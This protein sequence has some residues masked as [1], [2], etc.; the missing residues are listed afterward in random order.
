MKR[1]I[2]DSQTIIVVEPADPFL[3]KALLLTKSARPSA[4]AKRQ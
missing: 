4:E 1:D 3:K 2:P